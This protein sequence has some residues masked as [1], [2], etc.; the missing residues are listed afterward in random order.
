MMLAAL[1]FTF[2]AGAVAADFGSMAELYGHAGAKS[3]DYA[4]AQAH[5]HA[6][7]R[8]T[9]APPV[10]PAGT[11]SAEIPSDHGHCKVPCCG[12]GCTIAVL[13]VGVTLSSSARTAS[14]DTPAP[15]IASLTGTD[16]PG[17]ERP[18]RSLMAD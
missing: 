7:A 15:V 13:A 12:T 6:G 1:A 10:H 11:K 3:H 2:H 9:G 8:Q 18:P 17:L 14:S 16:P 5:L 4:D